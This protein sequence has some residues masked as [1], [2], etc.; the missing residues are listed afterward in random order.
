MAQKL[1]AGLP[2]VLD[3]DGGWT[4]Q[5]AALSPTDGSAVAGVKIT[6]GTMLVL[7]VGGGDLTSP[8]QGEPLWIPLPT[9]PLG[10]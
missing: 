6:A 8:A 1:T 3:F 4:I 5:I 9:V 2:P 10:G 7:N